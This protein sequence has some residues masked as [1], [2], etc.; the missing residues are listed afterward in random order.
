MQG[1]QM[2]VLLYKCSVLLDENCMNQALKRC[3]NKTVLEKFAKAAATG[4]TP[5]EAVLAVRVL[6]IVLGHQ[7]GTAGEWLLRC[8]QWCCEEP[9]NII[10]G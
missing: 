9:V 6:R 1:F 7:P 3:L 5:Q 10:R 8:S 4:E 2:H